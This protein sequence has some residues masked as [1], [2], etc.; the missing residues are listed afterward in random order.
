MKGLTDEKQPIDG[1]PSPTTAQAGG[2][3]RRGR[4]GRFIALLA[5]LGGFA[6]YH[7]VQS[8]QSDI[9]PAT[10]AYWSAVSSGKASTGSCHG[11]QTG[12]KGKHGWIT[13]KQAENIF[14][15]VP[16]N[17]SAAA[18]SK[19]Y[20]AHAHPAGNGW[21][22]VTAQQVK[23]D[24]E[25]ELGIS[26]SGVDESIYDAGTSE[27][28]DLLRTT[29]GKP[30][31]WV[32]TFYPLLNS[33]VAS[34]VT[35]HSDPPFHAKLREAT[36]EGD[37]DSE[38]ADE[39][40][41]FHGLSI[42]GDVQGKYVYAGYGLKS[43]F[44]LLQSKGVD[45]TGTIALVKYG[46]N[47][48]GLKVKAAQ[49]AGAIGCIIFT[50]PGDDG[51]IT[52]ANGYKPYPE[53]IA[54]VPSSVQRGSVQFLSMYPGDPTTPGEP[55]YKNAT[56]GEGKN[57]PSIPSLPISYEDAIPL[58]NA[59]K[60]KGHKASDIDDSFEGGLGYYG[61]E[62]WTGPSD[63]DLHLVNEV[64]TR[65]TPIWNNMAVIPGHIS[66]EAIFV[67]N[68][69]D[70][71]VLGGADPNSGTA[72]MYELVRGLGTLL[73]KGWKPMRTIILAA[74]D[75]EEYGLVGSTEFAEG[76]GD[77]L[78]KNVVSYHNLDSSA[79]GPNW[80]GAAS[81]S[82]ALLLRSI[83][84]EVQKSDSRSVWDA[85]FDGGGEELAPKGSGVAPLGSGSD[86]TAFL[87][88]YGIAATDFSFGGGPKAPVYHYHSIYDSYTWQRK[89]GDPEFQK[90]K[91][92]AQMIG[93][94][95]LRLAD[96]PILPLNSTQYAR[97]LGYYLEKVEILKKD[98]GYD[99]L[100][101]NGLGDAI[102]KL[103]DASA[104]LDRER[105]K[106]EKELRKLPR[107][108]WRQ[109]LGLRPRL[110]HGARKLFK[111]L[112]NVNYK[113]K[114]LES[115]FISEEGITD[116][117]WYKHK[118]TSPG[119]WLGYGATT[120]SVMNESADVSSLLLLRH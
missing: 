21:D 73:K 11:T 86:Y 59:L 33:P 103:A 61:V 97:D 14:V 116:R 35:L 105:S 51:E 27:S 36:L 96:S 12:Y 110:P 10:L 47:F 9:D 88:R 95:A 25:R 31:V 115:G 118:G 87:M 102:K 49:E 75:G 4:V 107:R 37:P 83:A 34:S 26:T 64:N 58:L 108:G 38:L 2:A 3:S 65:I 112:R 17:D 57:M 117:E 79:S 48:R 5:V 42:S 119:K 66:D 53:G 78:Q 80:H 8:D 55:A 71:W 6:L 52:E 29:Q 90:H 67:G 98:G 63:V 74:W 1:L 18:A 69:R 15:K 39:V 41:V 19:R 101:L 72:S 62:Y 46:H 114:K 111:A 60:G 45:F 24:W 32:D 50:D 20:T 120:V 30:K 56:R 91:E 113:L 22:F 77:W 54:R 28:R 13:P 40:R 68:H 76:E 43:D 16:T 94:L 104:T 23:N 81:P 92:A 99:D 109:C 84:E 85:R 106:L 82:L 44:E 7:L 93:L 89:Y 100:K 70:A